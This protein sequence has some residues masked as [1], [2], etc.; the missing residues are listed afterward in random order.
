M[1]DTPNNITKFLTALLGPAQDIENAL[2]QMITER[3]LDVATGAQL[4]IIGRIVG[5]DRGG[6]S[7]DDFRRYCRARI[8][9]HR[10]NGT[11]PEILSIIELLINDD[12]VVLKLKP[13]GVAAYVVE[14]SNIAVPAQLANIIVSFLRDATSGGVRPVLESS[15]NAPSTWFKWDTAGRGWDHGKWIDARDPAH[16][17]A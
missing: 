13:P 9:T 4:D 11:P 16:L 3:T 5:Q 15:A 6:L 7:D 2:A 17:S 12:T 10:S 1:A 14:V 8:V